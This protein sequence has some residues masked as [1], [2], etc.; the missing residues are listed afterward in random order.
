MSPAVLILESGD[1]AA[2]VDIL[3]VLRFA[4]IMVV[5]DSETSKAMAAVAVSAATLISGLS[6]SFNSPTAQVSDIRRAC[7]NSA[8]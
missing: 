4:V 7:L 8:H 1:E 2:P 3:K 6:I 5:R